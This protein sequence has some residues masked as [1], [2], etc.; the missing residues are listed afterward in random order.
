MR[1]QNAGRS[2]L[3]RAGLPVAAANLVSAAVWMLIVAALL[4]FGLWVAIVAAVVL[5]LMSLGQ[6][7]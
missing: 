5:V 7:D 6:A 4:R 1:L 3:V 2:T